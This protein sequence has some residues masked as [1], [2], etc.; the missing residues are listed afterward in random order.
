[1]SSE[2]NEA[3]L[4]GIRSSERNKAGLVWQ[5]LNG[6]D[7]ETCKCHCRSPLHK[8]VETELYGEMSSTQKIRVCVCVCGGGVMAIGTQK[9]G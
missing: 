7:R 1:M 9:M 8:G 5:T 3:G 6:V 2:R 4:D